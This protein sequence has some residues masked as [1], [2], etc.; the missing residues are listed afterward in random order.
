MFGGCVEGLVGGDEHLRL[1][2]TNARHSAITLI[3]Y[4]AGN[5][6]KGSAVPV[7]GRGTHTLTAFSKENQFALT[8]AR[9]PKGI[10]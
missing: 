4:K 6:T 8:A 5:N 3:L 9:K 2:V 10:R 7:T 1:D